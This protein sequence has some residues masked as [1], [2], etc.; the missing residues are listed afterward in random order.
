MSSMMNRAHQ[1]DLLV[2]RQSGRLMYGQ[3]ASRAAGAAQQPNALQLVEQP[4]SPVKKDN[5]L[6]F[7]AA[8][9]VVGYLLL[10]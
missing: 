4:N 10:K 9:L 6:I 7:I 2:A 5:T 8:A 3:D 1:M